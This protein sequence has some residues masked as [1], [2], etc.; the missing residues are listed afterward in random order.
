MPNWIIED[1][2]TRDYIIRVA[3]VSSFA[4]QSIDHQGVG[5]GGV[6]QLSLN[7]LSLE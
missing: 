5:I 7:E 3:E 2:A 1:H 6:T 4:A